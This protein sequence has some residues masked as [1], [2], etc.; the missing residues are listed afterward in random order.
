MNTTPFFEAMGLKFPEDET[1]LRRGHKRS[2]RRGNYEKP[3]RNAVSVHINEDDNVVELGTGIGFMSTF[4]AV[5]KGVKNITTFEANS[6]LLPYIR[7]MHILNGVENQIKVRNQLAAP[8]ASEPEPF[9]VRGDFLASS[10]SDDRG[11][12]FGGV[13]RTE[14][15][16]VIDFNT[17]LVQEDINALVCDVEGYESILLPQT[18]LSGLNKAIIELH[19]KSTGLAGVN[20]IFQAFSNAG[21]VYDCSTSS[22]AVVTFLR[23]S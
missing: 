15:I 14:M 13:V 6:G 1:V 16:D 8:K 17:F 4:M 20:D 23:D 19:P 3:E 10:L 5:T 18:D 22:G 11:T 12:R 9:Y 21:L 7:N 2:I